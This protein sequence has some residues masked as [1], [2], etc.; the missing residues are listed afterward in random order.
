MAFLAFWMVLIISWSD[1]FS[2]SLQSVTYSD[3]I[4]IGDTALI[5]TYLLTPPG[6][7]NGC[8]YSFSLGW[9][10]NP[11]MEFEVFS[12]EP[13]VANT[14]F[15][16]LKVGPSSTPF[17]MYLM[18]S[19]I[20]GCAQ[21]VYP[22]TM[23][24]F[25]LDD[26]FPKIRPL[27]LD[28]SGR[29]GWSITLLPDSLGKVWTNHSAPTF[30]NPI[31]DTTIFSNFSAKPIN[32][33]SCSLQVFDSTI[34]INQYIE[35]PFVRKHPLDLIFSSPNYLS[36]DTVIFSVRMQHGNI[37][38]TISYALP[39]H[40]DAPLAVSESTS[41]LSYALPDPFQNQLGIGFTLV[42]PESVKVTLYDIT[43]TEVYSREEN[44][45]PG[46][47]EFLIDTHILQPGTYFYAL[48]GSEWNR[49]GKLLKQ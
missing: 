7:E 46:I 47:R 49:S 18:G 20:H 33:A 41:D 5:G 35:L 29:F 24:G 3:S 30:D 4:A 11:F 34:P 43:G 32:G 13:W 28:R 48:R 1:A 42:R 21:N 25:G 27:P 45:D 9:G 39:V 6:P 22:I 38:S 31:S 15:L 2:Q 40:W 10:F 23:N 19:P 12:T 37:D 44:F 14:Y 36:F 8:E 26:S 17:S 16:P